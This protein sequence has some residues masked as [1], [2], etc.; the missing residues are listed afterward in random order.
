MSSLDDRKQAFENKFKMDEEFRFKVNSRAVK[1][2]GYWAAEQLGITG[3][4]ADAYAE[5]VV[6]SDFEEPGNQ[7][8]FRKVQKDFALKGMDVTLHHLENQFNVHLEEA[9]K[10]L[11]AG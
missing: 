5:E 11:M 8:V 4:E 2:L 9:K 1:L 10:S 3:A 7:D 6:D